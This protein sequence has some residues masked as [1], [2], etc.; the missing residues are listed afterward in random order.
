[1][2]RYVKNPTTGGVHLV[3]GRT[4]REILV[5]LRELSKPEKQPNY[6]PKKKKGIDVDR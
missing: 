3:V 4:P 5:L 2:P 1:M 6:L